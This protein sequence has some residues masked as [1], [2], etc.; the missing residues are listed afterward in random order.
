MKAEGYAGTLEVLNAVNNLWGWQVSAPEMVRAD[1]WQAMHDTFIRD[2]R[3]LDINQWFERQN[4]AAQA[5]IIERMVEAIRKG[6]WDAP[7]ETRQ[8]LAER[9][10]QL[11]ER[12]GAPKPE[13]VT[14]A[15]MDQPA[16]GFGL[17][18]AAADPA[19]EPGS[20]AA[21]QVQGNVMK[22]VSPPAAVASTP[23]STIVAMCALLAFVLIGWLAQH[24]INVR[25]IAT[26][27]K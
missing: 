24:R 9:W 11:S 26:E 20:A 15:F 10:Q 27:S 14:K 2:S 6:Y 8:E 19:R 12:D 1:Q 23:W 18:H 4:P 3:H 5:Q 13:D 22:P 21:E 25:R 7:R 17:Q 16:A